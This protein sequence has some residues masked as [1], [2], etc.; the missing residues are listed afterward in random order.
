MLGRAAEPDMVVLADRAVSRRHAR[1]ERAGGHL[2]VTD[3]GSA[4]GSYVDGEP[5][6]TRPLAIRDVLR[7][8]PYDITWSFHVVDPD[9]TNLVP[10]SEMRALR[11][12][13]D[14]PAA[15]ARKVVLAAEAHNRSAGHELDGFLSIEHG[16]LPVEPPLRALPASHR[17]WDEMVGHLPELFRRTTLRSAFDRLPVLDAGA[18]A[19][20]D[21][22]LLRASAMLGAFAH[23]YQYV[24]TAPPAALP[25][26]V[27][28]PWTEVSRR[29]GK[30]VP[31]VSYTD[32]FLYNWRLRDP[33]GP[34]RLD[35]MDL[36]VP[37]W[38]NAAERVFYLVTTEF[39]MA[40][41]P[42]LEAMLR[43][44][45]AVLADDPAACESALLDIHDQ[46]NH[47]TQV[48][49][50]QIDPNPRGAN[51]LDQVLW[52]KTVGTAGVP[53][54]DGAPSP[55]GTAQPQIHA[56]DAF[57]E[58][59]SYR[60]LV[61]QQSGLMAGHFPRHWVELV[62]ALREVS[63]RQYVTDSGRPALRGVYN[64]V[65]DAYAGDRGWMG[66]HRIK[67]YGF[68]EVAFKVGREVTTGAKFTGLFKD[69]TWD[70]I[71]DELAV[72]RDERRPSVGPPVAFGRPRSGRVVETRDGWTCHVDL[73]VAG[74]GVHHQ[75]G[76]RVGVLAEN[77]DDLVRRTL[78]ALQ[79][80]GDEIV[81]L[82][83]NWQSAVR[84][85]AG[86]THDTEVLPLRTVLT[87]ARIRPV[88]RE[89]AKRLLALSP[90][91]SLKRIVD[92]RME[93]QW[94]LWDVLNLLHS[95][96][97]DVTRLWK[98]DAGEPEALCAVVPPEDFRLYSI[99]SATDEGAPAETLRLVVGGLRYTSA[100]TPYSYARER[101]GSASNFLRRMATEPRHRDR[102][103]SLKIVPTPRFRLPV[104]PSAPV[105]MFAAGSGIAPFHGFVRARA[106]APGENLLFYGARTAGE[107]THH[108]DLA[109]AAAGGRLEVHTAFSRE[110][111]VTRFDAATGR[112]VTEPGA[113][114]R[115]AALI[116]GDEHAE[117]LWALLRD[118]SD[119]GR[120]AHVY[121]CGSAG[122]AVSVLDA[123]LAVV[124]RH[125]ASEEEARDVVRELAARGRLSQD[126]FTTYSGHAQLGTTY[127]VSD[128]VLHNSPGEGL[129][130][131]VSGGVYDVTEFAHLHVG[132]AH[133]VRN[134]TGLDATAAYRKVLHHVHSEVDALLGMYA[135]GSM[136]RLRFGSRWGVVL[137]PD[138]LR[139]MALEQL[140]TA[141]VRYLYLVVAMENAL[142]GDHG[143][144]H[145]TATRGEDP[146][147]LTPFKAQ[148]VVESHR[149]FLVSFLDGLVDDDL[150]EVWTATVGFCADDVDL[151]T[152][153]AAVAAL[154]ARPEYLLVRNSVAHVRGLVLAADPRTDGL[155]RVY[156]REDARVLREMK[157]ALREGVLAF[158]EHESDVVALGGDRLL[159]SLQKVL[160]TVG[161]Y[162]RRVA[163]GT[164]ALGI[165]ADLLPA[166][167]VDEPVPDDP[168]LP[169][170]GSRI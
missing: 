7:I 77:D 69:R 135:I 116:T 48:I 129:W 167:V 51:F 41:T 47:A 136:R 148:Y 67:A 161:D 142:A 119:G 160:E 81:A 138:G 16:F 14:T 31:A 15:P 42:V 140:W 163:A 88:T 40:L 60:S 82:T 63:V 93:D 110:D 92:S 130:M 97:Y 151:R 13:T 39:A 2:V 36:L 57:L 87:F 61:G 166:E 35:N 162:Y 118:G 27:L 164:A 169:G 143:F 94:E 147:E 6:T 91:G 108:D 46:L 68:L 115:L 1:L 11:R 4:N 50:P 28:R 146:R 144:V 156:A 72:V 86:Y 125:V 134:H 33:S 56:I 170:H 10:P 99:A 29:L 52:A 24:T 102:Q 78:R 103:L 150:H 32:L 26:A 128:L 165:T 153:D 62:A 122:F 98:A 71:D 38:D 45:E 127:D 74:Q 149:R 111:V 114:R 75:P 155:C 106:G 54:F 30:P 80:T 124:R 65:L 18:G 79:A 121:I 123:L 25:E 5:V 58:R 158:E 168:G 8:G 76:D 34:R 53:I 104:D 21:R 95:A 19:L 141:W 59:R 49:Y 85:R 107:F 132:G 23:A 154:R 12:S 22:Y 17:A 43:A 126:V 112:F 109:D 64:A 159:A 9:A 96:G 73:D 137:T 20:P 152:L 105:V 66:L 131:A 89:V 3:L 37:A 83:P 113:R 117:R 84:L 44:Q 133:I 145:S 101:L 70:H 55:A 120:G 157:L 100:R 139:H 90:T